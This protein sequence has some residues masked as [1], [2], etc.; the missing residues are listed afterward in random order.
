M[1]AICL[2]EKVEPARRG[3]GANKD[4]L[5]ALQ[6]TAHVEDDPRRI[7]P[8]EFDDVAAMRGDATALIS[9]QESFSFSEL[10]A[11]SNR[12][13]RW[14]IAQNLGIGDAVCLMMG[15]RA[16]YVAIW[17]GLN[18]VGVVVALLN[19]N[20]LDA[21]LANCIAI[22]HA[23]HVIVAEEF[24]ALT[25]RT[26]AQGE[27]I[28]EIFVHGGNDESL[29]RIDL[30][31]ARLSAAPLA[32]HEKRDVA[33]SNHALY[34]YTSGTTGLPKAAVVSHRRL[35]NWCLWFSG[36][37][38][39]SP[40]DRMYNCLPM[41]HSIGGVVAVWAMLLAGGSVVI[42]ERFS[43]GR[44]WKDLVAF[45]CTLFQYIGE[46]CR[47]L[48]N[49]PPSTEEKR[50]RLRLCVGNGLR[51][52]VWSA[53]QRRF[54]IPRILEF[55]A[56]TESNF[57]LYNVEGEPGAI[58]RVPPFMAH[59]FRVEIVKCDFER[60]EA[61]RNEAGRCIRCEPDEVG[62]AIAAIEPNARDGSSNFE[63][64]LNRADWQKKVL[65]DVFAPGDAWMRSGDLM[66][67]DA[68]GFYY[69]VDRIGETF[70]WKGENVA[71]SEVAAAIASF[72]GVL[73]VNVYGV[74]VAGCDGRAGMAALA[75]DERFELPALIRHIGDRLPD[76]ARPLFWRICERLEI[77]DTF[78]H[79]KQALVAQ[80]FDPGNISDPIYFVEP[81]TH[82][83]IRMDEALFGRI[84]AGEIR[85]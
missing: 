76:Y 74:A 9:E 25:L 2:D 22:S 61:L 26:I 78:K 35:M 69:F 34:I 77:T 6:K 4:W 68:R 7:L 49:T 11:R 47:Y 8:I 84:A 43:S 39:A 50:H 5:R 18:R 55:Y 57:S 40:S 54:A 62:E 72:P 80:G 37:V 13:A 46:L 23:R 82:A 85:L 63:G 33:L 56:A 20:L 70:R 48:I 41:Y 15:N 64:Y 83:F 45:D 66:R 71:T 16:E 27:L 12:Y 14:A 59:R 28:A 17:L 24:R 53:F 19:T 42:R 51:P 44:F 1:S 79:K 21:S 60:E 58:G 3:S 65:R 67:K 38:D 36:L 29:S 75:V 73:E 31:V 30:E 81:R 32:E 52:D 10:V